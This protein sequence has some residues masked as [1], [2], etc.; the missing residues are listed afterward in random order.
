MLQWREENFWVICTKRSSA[1]QQS[2]MIN[3]LLLLLRKYFLNIKVGKSKSFF[4]IF[5]L[6][7]IIHDVNF[8]KSN[9][10][11]LSLMCSWLL[12][13]I[14][15]SEFGTLSS[16]CVGLIKKSNNLVVIIVGFMYGDTSRATSHKKHLTI[17]LRMI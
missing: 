13:F 3:D 1:V 14:F 15:F 11:I 10:E 5:Q 6:F 7:L 2:P 8:L 17:E 9:N 4:L 12:F 16:P